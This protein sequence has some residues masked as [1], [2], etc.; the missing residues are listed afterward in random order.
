MSQNIAHNLG[1][2]ATFDLPSRV[3]VPEDVRSESV[4]DHSGPSCILTNPVSNGTA[5]KAGV[6]QGFGHEELISEGMAGSAPLEVLGKRL[7]YAVHQWQLDADPRLG[8]ADLENLRS[9][10]DVTSP[11]ADHLAGSQ[12][13]RSHQQKHRVITSAHRVITR[14]AAQDALDIGPRQCPRRTIE[15]DEPRRD[16]A[17]GKIAVQ[18][19][20]HLHEAKE[21][22]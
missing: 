19:A 15:G 2:R 4:S 6:W 13:I 3:A 14:D 10:V 12:A 7:R 18:A 21:A 17:A 22:P 9:P 20:G 1:A 8:S 11:Q 5:R 16:H